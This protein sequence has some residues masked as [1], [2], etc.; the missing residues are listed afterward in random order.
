MHTGR[1]A[2]A[3]SLMVK[4]HAVAADREFEPSPCGSKA[5]A[6]SI[7][8]TALMFSVLLSAS[9]APRSQR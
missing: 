6:L 1:R 5:R 4:K 7:P 8:P 2:S 3:D 9:C